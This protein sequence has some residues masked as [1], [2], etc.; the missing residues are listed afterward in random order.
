MVLDEPAAPQR[1]PPAPQGRAQQRG[2]PRHR[3]ELGHQPGRIEPRCRL[4]DPGRRRLAEPVR[5][6]PR[7]A[8]GLRHVHG[9][10][11]V[12]RLA[13]GGRHALTELGAA[14]L[15]MFAIQ[16]IHQPGADSDSTDERK[17]ASH[18]SPPGLRTIF[19]TPSSF[20]DHMWYAAGAADSGSRCEMI[21]AGSMSPRAMRSSR[22]RM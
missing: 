22:G 10:D 2:P 16:Q 6:A 7:T 13:H 19:V 18:V 20:A 15:S 4:P 3:R 5:G 9:V 17:R 14:P 11:V 1:Q 12:S 8:G 21:A